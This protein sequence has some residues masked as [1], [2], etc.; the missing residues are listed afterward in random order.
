MLVAEVN[1]EHRTAV[2]N[3]SSTLSG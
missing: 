2:V 3:S 1:R